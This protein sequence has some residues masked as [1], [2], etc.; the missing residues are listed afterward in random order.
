MD[1]DKSKSMLKPVTIARFTRSV[2]PD[3]TTTFIP[4]IEFLCRVGCLFSN[5][6]SPS[7]RNLS[8]LSPISNVNVFF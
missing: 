1:F 7:F 5:T 6:K 3:F 8:T 4:C 2:F